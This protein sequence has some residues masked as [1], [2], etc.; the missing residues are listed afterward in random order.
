M[1]KILIKIIPINSYRQTL[2]PI[3]KNNFHQF[4]NTLVQ[5]CQK[6]DFWKI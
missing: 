2:C 4:L 6:Y 3:W 1:W 5:N